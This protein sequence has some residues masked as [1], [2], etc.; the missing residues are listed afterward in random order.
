[1]GKHKNAN[2]SLDQRHPFSL[3]LKKKKERERER[4]REREGKILFAQN[5]KECCSER[6]LLAS[7]AD[8]RKKKLNH[9]ALQSCHLNAA[10]A[11]TFH[12][13]VNSINVQS[14]CSPSECP[15]YSFIN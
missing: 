4:E 9:R 10:T 3:L 7:R 6:A 2:C 8:R 12:T 13:P 1:M 5:A 11:F 14:T 15:A